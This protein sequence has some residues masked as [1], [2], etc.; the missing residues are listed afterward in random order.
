[1]MHEYEDRQTLL[2]KCA[3]DAD[4]LAQFYIE[5]LLTWRGNKLA[6]K[7]YR[8]GLKHRVPNF[9]TESA[10]KIALSMEGSSPQEWWWEEFV[11]KSINLDHLISK[12]DPTSNK[13]SQV[14]SS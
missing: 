4:G 9:R 11:E 10:K 3:K 12:N 8:L 1:M 2:A 5:W 7:W 6:E 14:S 13:I